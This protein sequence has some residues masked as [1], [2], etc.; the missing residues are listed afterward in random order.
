[1]KKSSLIVPALFTVFASAALG[2]GTY[3]IITYA[4]REQNHRFE[5]AYIYNTDFASSVNMDLEMVGP[6]DK[7]DA[8]IP[9]ISTIYHRVTVKMSFQGEKT[10][11]YDYLLVS[12]DEQE[13]MMSLSSFIDNNIT[14]E[15]TLGAKQE[16]NVVMYYALSKEYSGAIVKDVYFSIFIRATDSGIGVLVV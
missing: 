1:M 3:F 12:F 6:G 16:K 2:L 4:R 15:F 9:V 13:N 11:I 5:A 7:A 10:D 14:Y 8:T